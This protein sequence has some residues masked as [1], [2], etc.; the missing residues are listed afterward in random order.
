M[1]SCKDGIEKDENIALDK[2][3]NFDKEKE[4]LA[5]SVGTQGYLFGVSLMTQ[6]YFRNKMLKMIEVSKDP[7]SPLK[8]S[9]SVDD[10]L[11]FNELVHTLNL[12]NHLMKIGGTPNVDTRYSVMFF[13]LAQGAQI[14][15]VPPIK[16]RYFSINITDAYLGN[17]PYICSRKGDTDG[18]NYL[19]TG[20]NFKGKVP[21]NMQEIKMPQNNFMVVL[22]IFVKDRDQDNDVVTTIQNQFALLSLDKYQNKNLSEKKVAVPKV[23]IKTGVDYFEQM[24]GFMQANPPE[25]YQEFIWHMFRQ[26]G[27]SKTKPFEASNLSKPYYEGLERGLQKGKDIIDWKTWKRSA[28]TTSNWGYSLTMGVDHEDYLH[29]SEWAVQGLTVGSPIEAIF[30]NTFEDGEGNPLDGAKNY[31]I[32]IPAD[33]MP[34]VN[35]FWSITS[36]GEDFNIVHNEDLHYGVGSRDNDKMAYNH[37]GSLT[38]KVQHDK[39]KEGKWNWIPT[40]E[41]GPFKLNFRFYNPKEVMLDPK[42]IDEYLPPIVE[43]KLKN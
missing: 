10:G 36:Y 27:V 33:K 7:K 38:F 42:T 21:A 30:F 39:P 19:F 2:I 12:A 41:S 18:G 15:K 26:I 24:I 13:D 6:M 17:K 25:P 32:N 37:D 29:R 35:E 16:D 22:R 4:Q 23:S 31:T 11:H 8:F 9:A 14:L 43:T 5:E 40:P 3:K 28:S 34:P 20:P 1:I